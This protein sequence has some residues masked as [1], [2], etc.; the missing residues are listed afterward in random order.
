M[1]YLQPRFELI[2]KLRFIIL[3]LYVHQGGGSVILGW[4][5]KKKHKHYYKIENNNS[6]VKALTTKYVGQ[7][8]ITG[9]G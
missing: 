3:P 1:Q 4:P 8:T 7:N 5:I 9:L 6:L 2:T